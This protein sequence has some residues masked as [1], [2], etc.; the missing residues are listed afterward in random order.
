MNTIPHGSVCESSQFAGGLWRVEWG[1]TQEV[2]HDMTHLKLK[3]VLGSLA[4]VGAG[5]VLT[6]VATPAFAG[7]QEAQEAKEPNEAA[8]MAE[9]P[10]MML[11]A[12]VGL[13]R[14][15]AVATARVPGYVNEAK[16]DKEN[17]KLIWDL[18]VVTRKGKLYGVDVDA[19]TGKVLM[20]GEEKGE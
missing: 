13:V 5:T 14:A 9:A 1:G 6:A 3:I 16:L 19:R 20:S 8:E 12:P 18:D 10:N 15:V 17:G 2:P 7:G 4:L 11:T